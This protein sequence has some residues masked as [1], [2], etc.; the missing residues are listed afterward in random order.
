MGFW[1]YLF[2]LGYLGLL[3][4]ESDS[5]N[6]LVYLIDLMVAVS[7]LSLSL[8]RSLIQIVS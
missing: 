3:S 8:F 5:L 7:M 6:R 1:K 4:Q 2:R